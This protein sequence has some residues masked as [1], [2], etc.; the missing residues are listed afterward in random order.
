MPHRPGARQRPPSSNGRRCQA[1]HRSPPKTSLQRRR[2]DSSLHPARRAQDVFGQDQDEPGGKQN[3]LHRRRKPE[4]MQAN[5]ATYE[6]EEDRQRKA[7]VVNEEGDQLAPSSCEP[8]HHATLVRRAR[9]SGTSR[10]AIPRKAAI[11]ASSTRSPPGHSTPIPSP[12]QKVPNAE[13]STP[14]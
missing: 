6:P 7:A 5:R 1:R 2:P 3:P 9:A 10:M 8:A 14:T 4:G 13:S 12:A 11:S